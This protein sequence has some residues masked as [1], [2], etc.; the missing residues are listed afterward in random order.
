[1]K[2]REFCYIFHIWMSIPK[3]Y[4]FEARGQTKKQQIFK[5]NYSLKITQ[6]ISKRESGLGKVVP[7]EKLQLKPILMRSKKSLTINFLHKNCSF[8]VFI[9]GTCQLILNHVR[10]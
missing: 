3:Y 8:V 6:I 4:I 2:A 10:N 1:M 7:R 5:S 9:V